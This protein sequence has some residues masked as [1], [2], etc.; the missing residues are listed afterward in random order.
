[1]L[2][3]RCMVWPRNN[4]RR[5]K[6]YGRS[7]CLLAISFIHV[8]KYQRPGTTYM[9]VVNVNPAVSC[10]PRASCTRSYPHVFSLANRNMWVCG[11]AVFDMPPNGRKSWRQDND[12]HTAIINTSASFTVVRYKVTVMAN[13]TYSAHIHTR[14]RAYTHTHTC[15]HTHT[16]TH[17]RSLEPDPL[18]SHSNKLLTQN[19]LHL[20]SRYTDQSP[21]PQASRPSLRVSRILRNPF[22]TAFTT[23]H[24]SL[25]YVRWIK[26]TVSHPFL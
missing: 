2:L 7:I 4:T 19:N 24:L 11:R 26:S 12:I 18:T 15:T 8:F 20:Q 25:S 6:M 13:P 21:A 14:A 22:I 16:H 9:G 1:M 17:T 5:K 10:H 23:G 3:N